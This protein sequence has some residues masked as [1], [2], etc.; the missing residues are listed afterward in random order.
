MF[1]GV[2]EPDDYKVDQRPDEFTPVHPGGMVVAARSHPQRRAIPK[3]TTRLDAGGN[4]VAAESME[5]DDGGPVR[6][7]TGSKAASAMPVYGC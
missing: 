7:V 5:I 6:D 3:G 2:L 1:W 4:G